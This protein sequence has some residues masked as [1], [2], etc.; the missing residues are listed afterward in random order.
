MEVTGLSST[1]QPLNSASIQQDRF[2]GEGSAIQ[3]Q[4]GGV[5]VM[6]T[7]TTQSAKAVPDAV[8]KGGIVDIYA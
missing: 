7:P 3:S 2:V 6:Q 8:G 5:G 4:M 1:A